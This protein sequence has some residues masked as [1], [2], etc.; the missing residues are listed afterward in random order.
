MA[1]L[2]FPASP[3]KNQE[4]IGPN[5]VT[6][7]FDGK[8]WT[9]AGGSGGGGGGGF[10][11]DDGT[12]LTPTD[13]RFVAVQ[14]G[15]GY[16]FGVSESLIGQDNQATVQ[17]GSGGI[18][19]VTIG[20]DESVLNFSNAGLV[21]PGFGLARQY[22]TLD[23]A[24][25]IG[26]DAAGVALDGMLQYTGSKFQGRV[27]GVWVDIPGTPVTN[28]WADDVTNKKLKPVTLDRGIAIASFQT[29][30]WNADGSPS[31]PSISGGG[32][33]ALRLCAGLSGIEFRDQAEASVYASFDSIGHLGMG[34]P[35]PAGGER[36]TLLSTDGAIRLGASI[37]STTADGTVQLTGTT[38]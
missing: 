8:V 9:A 19:R 27:A 37:A 13:V 10:W 6:Y 12:A 17:I 18:Y 28:Y 22:A 3:T 29:I 35:P 16:Q 24:L 26:F 14:N 21:G 36:R 34:V 38:W 25:Q 20:A 2:D 32:G 33:N 5:G 30:K 23:H 31:A 1:V 4:W 7:T 11:S 15:K